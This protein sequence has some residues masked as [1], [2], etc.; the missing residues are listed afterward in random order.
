M[1]DAFLFHL[2]SSFR[3]QDIKIILLTFWSKQHDYKDKVDLTAWLTNNC[4]A[5]LVQYLEK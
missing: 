5:Y 1:G 4:D 3:S 2:K